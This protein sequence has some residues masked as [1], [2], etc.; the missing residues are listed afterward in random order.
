MSFKILSSILSIWF[1]R[2][3]KWSLFEC[4]RNSRILDL[5]LSQCIQNRGAKFWHNKRT[6]VCVRER[7]F[8]SLSMFLVTL[9]GESDSCPI[10]LSLTQL[11]CQEWWYQNSRD[12]YWT[13]MPHQISFLTLALWRL[14]RSR[15]MMNTRSRFLVPPVVP[16]VVGGRG[17]HSGKAG[18]HGG[19]ASESFLYINADGTLGGQDG[20]LHGRVIYKLLIP[21]FDIFIAPDY[22]WALKGTLQELSP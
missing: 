12:F 3:V 1:A 6:E 7:T 20:E 19:F 4:R 16:K 11:L 17:C 15:I 21:T 10:K 2:D 13:F 14:Q 9:N 18:C 22:R 8:A 5:K